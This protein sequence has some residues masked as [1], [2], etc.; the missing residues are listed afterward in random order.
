MHCY[1]LGLLNNTPCFGVPASDSICK[2]TINQLWCL[3]VLMCMCESACH[4]LYIVC[5]Q[6]PHPPSCTALY[7]PGCLRQSTPSQ[8]GL[9]YYLEQLQQ[10]SRGRTRSEAASISCDI[11][12]ISE[13]PCCHGLQCK[14]ALRMPRL[15]LILTVDLSGSSGV[16]CS[17]FGCASPRF[18]SES[19]VSIT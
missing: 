14:H 11:A 4:V 7:L 1:R 15:N 3:S 19:C 12:T 8:Y 18:S 6:H 13:S 9:I 10:R 2:G 5:R 16:R 17:P